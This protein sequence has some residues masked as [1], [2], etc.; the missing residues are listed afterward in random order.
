MYK[1]E[2]NYLDFIIMPKSLKNQ[3]SIT[4]NVKPKSSRDYLILSGDQILT[5]IK[6]R[7]RKGKANKRIIDL[8]SDILDIPKDHIKILRGL[9]SRI[10]EIEIIGMNYEQF[11]K[12]ISKDS[13]VQM[14][15]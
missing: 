1:M 12:T 5:Y 15:Q 9:K 8:F 2:D 11:Y 7:P 10:K 4:L 3:V 14:K 13:R 6:A